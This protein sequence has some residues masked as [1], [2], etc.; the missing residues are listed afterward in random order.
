MSASPASVKPPEKRQET[1]QHLIE[2][3]LE[4]ILLHG[5]NVVSVDKLVKAAGVP[6]GSFYHYFESKEDFGLQVVAFFQEEKCNAYE[7]ALNQPEGTP[8]SRLA[9]LF[10]ANN[11]RFVNEA[12]FCGGCLI[13]NLAQEQASDY[14]AFQAALKGCYESWVATVEEVFRSAV[15]SKELPAATN[16]HR[17]TQALFIAM[18]GALLTAKLTR[19]REPLDTAWWL[20]F[21][22][23]SPLRRDLGALSANGG[24]LT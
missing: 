9:G 1:R 10:K 12:R 18:E 20:F 7:A 19:S 24:V 2:V 4:L 3:G 11:D 22:A 14:P 6:K 21:D 16:T 13:G 17:L 8:F 23:D 15:L 5:F